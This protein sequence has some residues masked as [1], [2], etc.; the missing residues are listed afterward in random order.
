MV[1]R[2]D[3]EGTTRNGAGFKK[4]SYDKL[5]LSEKEERCTISFHPDKVAVGAEDEGVQEIGRE[6]YRPLCL[7]GTL[8]CSVILR[9]LSLLSMQTMHF[10][11]WRLLL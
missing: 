8:L 4:Y 5:T 3:Y 2:K 11:P 7:T 1:R 9:Q 6:T 10:L